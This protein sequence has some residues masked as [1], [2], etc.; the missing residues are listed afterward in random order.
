MPDKPRKADITQL[1]TIIRQLGDMR[2]RIDNM[3]HH[4]ADVISEDLGDALN[5]ACNARD[6]MV[7]IRDGEL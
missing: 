1:D 2:D 5:T 3:K 6:A 4:Y 7:Q